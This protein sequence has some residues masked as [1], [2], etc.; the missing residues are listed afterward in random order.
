MKEKNKG[1]EKK[2]RMVNKRKNKMR[3]GEIKEE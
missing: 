2:V 3:E 1:E